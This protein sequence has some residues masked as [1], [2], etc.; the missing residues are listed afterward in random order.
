[1][2]CNYAE[3]QVKK[4]AQE[5]YKTTFLSAF[6]PLTNVV[7]ISLDPPYICETRVNQLQDIKLCKEGDGQFF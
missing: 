2:N 3:M 5:Y 6:G 1:M 4:R 7:V